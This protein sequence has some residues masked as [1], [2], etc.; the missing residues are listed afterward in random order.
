MKAKCFGGVATKV[1]EDDNWWSSTSAAGAGSG[2]SDTT[3]TASRTVAVV[4]GSCV[5]RAVGDVF[6]RAGI[7]LR[8]RERR[9]ALDPNDAGADRLRCAFSR[10]GG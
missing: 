6:A 4:D 3:W 5:S 8:F 7:A 1:D 2:V 9:T 10:V